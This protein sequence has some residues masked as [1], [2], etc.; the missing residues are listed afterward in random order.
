M[1]QIIGVPLAVTPSAPSAEQYAPGW[2]TD[3][4]DGAGAGNAVVGG[5]VVVGMVVVGMVVVGMVV[6]GMAVGGIVVVES[7]AA[8]AVVAED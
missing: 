3:K 6:V 4:L 1:V 7:D 2:T 5:I 8:V